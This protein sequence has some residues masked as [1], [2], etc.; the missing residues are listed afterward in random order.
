[1]RD[2]AWKPQTL[3]TH[4][5][6]Q[7]HMAKQ[8]PSRDWLEQISHLMHSSQAAWQLLNLGQSIEKRIPHLLG[9]AG[10]LH[11]NR[12]S[13]IW[14]DFSE[15]L[16]CKNHNF[17]RQL[18]CT[19]R[20]TWHRPFTVSYTMWRMEFPRKPTDSKRHCVPV[21]MTLHTTPPDGSTK[22]HGHRQTSA[23]PTERY[24]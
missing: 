13:H 9:H 10:Q 20:Q 22:W 6:R 18:M 12:I 21:Y 23:P 8:P 2:H 1:M 19:R 3:V 17:Y 7:P 11:T 4:N 14:L 24:M 16:C 5:P 15:P